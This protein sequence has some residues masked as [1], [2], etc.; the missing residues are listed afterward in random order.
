MEREEQAMQDGETGNAVNKGH[1]RRA[2]IE[3][4]LG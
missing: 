4:G 3:A 2:R 1:D